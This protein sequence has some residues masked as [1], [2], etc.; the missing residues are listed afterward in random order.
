M[1][2]VKEMLAIDVSKMLVRHGESLFGLNG[3]SRS[4]HCGCYGRLQEI[5]S[6]IS[7]S[8]GAELASARVFH[9]HPFPTPVAAL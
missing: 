2:A 8:R 4:K 3:K 1:H 5:A 9:R 7:S 6:S